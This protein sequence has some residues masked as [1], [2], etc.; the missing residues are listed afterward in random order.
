MKHTPIATL[1]GLVALLGTGC[2]NTKR[3]VIAPT[4]RVAVSFA[5][6]AASATFHDA[7][8]Q[9]TRTAPRAESS[10]GIHL[11][12]INYSTRTIQGPASHF[13][14]AVVMSDHNKDG[15]IT[16]AE[17]T[18]FATLVGRKPK[19]EATAPADAPSA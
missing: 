2:I 12:L 13:N 8:G 9:Y 14:H 18:D 19:P 16:E 17:A 15:I 11:I 4:Q 7:L 5:S 6:E 3:T 1:L 10:T